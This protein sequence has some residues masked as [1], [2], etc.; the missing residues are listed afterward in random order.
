LASLIPVYDLPSRATSSVSVSVKNPDGFPHPVSRA[1]NASA[2]TNKLLGGPLTRQGG[3]TQ[4]LRAYKLFLQARTAF[5]LNSKP[6]LEAARTEDAL[7]LRPNLAEAHF[8]LEYVHRSYDRDWPAAEAEG[9]V[10]LTLDPTNTLGLV[11]AGMLSKTLGRWDDAERQ[12]S[13]AL[14]RDPLFSYAHYNLASVLYG[15]GRFVEAEASYRKLLELAPGFLWTR[16][17]LAKTLLAR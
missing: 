3:G 1:L 11:V 9:R 12:L 5:E 17:C 13:V 2:S 14:I 15:A 16:R 4:D 8:I 7:Q 6:S 10:G